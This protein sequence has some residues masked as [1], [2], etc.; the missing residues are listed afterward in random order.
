[1]LIN[2]CSSWWY[3]IVYD[4]ACD[5]DEPIRRFSFSAIRYFVALLEWLGGGGVKAHLV[6]IYAY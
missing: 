2:L 1:M 5:I 6:L 4:I 3:F